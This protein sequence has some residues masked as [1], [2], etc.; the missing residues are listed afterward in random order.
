MLLLLIVFFT[1]LT[2]YAYLSGKFKNCGCFGDC[3]PITA[4][5]SFIK[6]IVL[7][8]LILLIFFNTKYIKPLF[9]KGV[10]AVLLLLIT[11]FSFA[12][13]WYT[14]KYLPLADCLPFKKGNNIPQQ[15]MMPANAI[16]D[17][18]VITFV[19]EKDGKNVEF[20]AETFPTDFN[21]STYK[22]VSR[23][24]KVIRPGINNEPPIK[25][26]GLTDMEG[27]DLTQEIL[28]KDEVLLLFAENANTPI[29]KWQEEFS[30]IVEKARKKNV[31]V[32]IVT[33][34]ATALKQAI[35]TTSF[36]NIELLN[37]DNT[38]IRMAARTNPT[39]YILRKGTIAGKWSYKNF[40]EIDI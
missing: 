28:S 27:N 25:A 19:Y 18:T 20:T 39:L 7:L 31:P 26:F 15:M 12:S 23:Y 36:K 17:S 32:Y 24:D 5:T 8:L 34:A 13:Q 11:I 33:S 37:G 2:G 4:K 40:D 35:G 29:T 6:D 10:V 3:L 14:L 22:F 16:P 38:M 21:D 1:F 9:A 30:E